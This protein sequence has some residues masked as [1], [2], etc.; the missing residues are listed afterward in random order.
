[1]RFLR[2]LIVGSF[3]LQMSLWTTG[4]VVTASGALKTEETYE[5]IVARL[6]SM[7]EDEHTA[8]ILAQGYVQDV[9]AKN[10]DYRFDLRQILKEQLKLTYRMKQ[11]N[12]PFLLKWMLALLVFGAVA[13]LRQIRVTRNRKDVYASPFEAIRA[14]RE[15]QQG[16]RHNIKKNYRNYKRNG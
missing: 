8:S 11:V 1:M 14:N 13:I 16:Y 5:E 15:I 7:S 10:P 12:T 4:P 6:E 2:F 3:F 9:F